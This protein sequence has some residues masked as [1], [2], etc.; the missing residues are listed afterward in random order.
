VQKKTLSYISSLILCL[1]VFTLNAQ[2]KIIESTDTIKEPI[3]NG[4]TVQADIASAIIPLFSNNTTYSYEAGI[5]VDLKHK[6]FPVIEL[7]ISGANKITTENIGF[8]TNAPFGRI[9]I[10]INLLKNKKDTKPT[11]NLFVAGVR[12]GMTNFNYKITN[13]TITNDYWGGTAIVDYSNT[14]TCTK[15]WWEIVAGVRVEVVKNIFMGW[16]I[17]DRNLINQDADGTVAPWYIPGFGVNAA[18]NWGF[19]YTIGYHF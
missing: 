9:G 19:N 5:Q 16:T 13:A 1:T 18:N 17:R 10:D 6:F 15:V 2:K 3:Y 7:G 11:N 12:L 4:F 14:P 8:V